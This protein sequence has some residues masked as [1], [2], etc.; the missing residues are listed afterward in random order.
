[1]H[2]D[3]IHITLVWICLNIWNF[4]NQ[5]A[6]PTDCSLSLTLTIVCLTRIWQSLFPL[7]VTK[8][9]SLQSKL[10]KPLWSTSSCMYKHTFCLNTAKCWF[11]SLVP[12]VKC[13]HCRQYDL[14]CLSVANNTNTQ[15]C[16]V[17][18]GHILQW[19]LLS[20]INI[21]GVETKLCLYI[22]KVVLLRYLPSL[23]GKFERFVTK[24]MEKAIAKLESDRL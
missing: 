2:F 15:D 9:S 19:D 11:C 18:N 20:K 7:F 16:I 1:M 14:A 17:G 3:A 13:A 8:R 6:L 22:H 4:Q 5:K 24:K 23:D 21:C 10:G 12:V